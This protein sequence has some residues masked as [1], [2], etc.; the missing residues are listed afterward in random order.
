MLTALTKHSSS[1]AK[2]YRKWRGYIEY[3][4]DDYSNN[5]FDRYKG[6]LFIINKRNGGMSKA[7]RIARHWPENI[8]QVE[9]FYFS[10]NLESYISSNPDRFQL[11]WNNDRVRVYQIDVPKI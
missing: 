5:P 1:R 3:N 2:F 11:L 4:F 6:Y 9:N 7:G 10:E 8:L